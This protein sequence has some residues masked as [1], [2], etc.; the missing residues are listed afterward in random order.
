MLTATRN[1]ARCE[2]ISPRMETTS[3]SAAAATAFQP[4]AAMSAEAPPPSAAA[5]IF[6][7]KTNGASPSRADSADNT[8]EARVRRR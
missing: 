1:A 2:H 3:D 7:M 6:Q 5:Q 4:Q 8:H